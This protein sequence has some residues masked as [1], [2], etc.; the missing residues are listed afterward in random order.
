MKGKTAGITH[1][2]RAVGTVAT[3]SAASMRD[4]TRVQ[5]DAWQRY[6]RARNIQQWLRDSRNPMHASTR[7]SC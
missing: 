6:C 3:L 5:V 7:Q 4:T 1:W 2:A